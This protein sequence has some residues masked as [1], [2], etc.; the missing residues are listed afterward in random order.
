MFVEICIDLLPD[1][2]HL[3]HIKT[4]LVHVIWMESLLSGGLLTNRM[5]IIVIIKTR[6]FVSVW[7]SGL[8]G[9]VSM[10]TTTYPLTSVTKRSSQTL[11]RADYRAIFT[12]VGL[13]SV[14]QSH[15]HHFWSGS[16]SINLFLLA[17]GLSP[18]LCTF[19]MNKHCPGL[20]TAS[21]ER[22]TAN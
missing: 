7:T 22:S 21:S 14:L 16:H 10:V 17:R 13:M 5:Y 20:L 8:R 19:L 1:L 15:F 2:W 4:R 11:E 3:L 6:I 12:A 9:L 18:P